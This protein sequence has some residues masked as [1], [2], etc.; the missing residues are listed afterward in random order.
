MTYGTAD[1]WKA[2]DTDVKSGYRYT[3][4]SLILFLLFWLCPISYLVV[5]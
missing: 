2:G 4:G 3:I 1:K 5:C